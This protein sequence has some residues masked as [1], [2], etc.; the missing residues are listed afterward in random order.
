MVNI[1]DRPSKRYMV[2]QKDV[3]RSTAIREGDPELPEG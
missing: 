3:V 1:T 2:R